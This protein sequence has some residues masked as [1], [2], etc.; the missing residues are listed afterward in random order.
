MK[1]NLLFILLIVSALHAQHDVDDQGLVYTNNGKLGVGITS[2]ETILHIKQGTPHQGIQITEE[3]NTEKIQLHLAQFD[4]GRHYGYF[5]LGRETMLRGN[6]E[7]SYFKGSLGIGTI[8]PDAKLTV[9]GDIHAKELRLD[10]QGWPDYVFE[11]GYEL[12]PIEEVKKHI[13]EKGHLPDVPSAKKIEEDGLNLGDMDKVLM[14][15]IEELTLYVIQ[16]KEQNDL[17]N[18]EIKNLKSKVETYE[19]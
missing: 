3:G 10:I 17:L 16:L 6:G 8:H 7:K 13:E 2:P 1:K 4:D 9:N 18:Q 5:M 19:N 15:K 12:Q 11:S 14:R